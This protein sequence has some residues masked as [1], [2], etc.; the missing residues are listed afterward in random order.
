MAPA[1]SK[2]GWLVCCWLSSAFASHPRGTEAPAIDRLASMRVG[3]LQHLLSQ[4]NSKCPG[5]VE[6]ADYV[7]RCQ[8]VWQELRRAPATVHLVSSEYDWDI[9]E[10]SEYE[11]I[12]GPYDVTEPNTSWVIRDWRRPRYERRRC[13]ASVLALYGSCPVLE[14]GTARALA[15]DAWEEI[16]VQVLL[17]GPSWTGWVVSSSRDAHATPD[18][19][20]HRTASDALLP[21]TISTTWDT[22]TTSLRRIWLRSKLFKV[23]AGDAGRV[24]WEKTQRKA[25]QRTDERGRTGLLRAACNGKPLGRPSS[26]PEEDVFQ[27]N[28][29]LVGAELE[30]HSQVLVTGTPQSDGWRA[31]KYHGQ[32][33]RNCSMREDVKRFHC[34]RC[35]Y[36]CKE[37]G[38]SI[39]FQVTETDSFWYLVL[40]GSHGVAF[41][42]NL[43]EAHA[44]KS[45]SSTPVDIANWKYI[46][47]ESALMP[48]TSSA[49]NLQ[50]TTVQEL[51]VT[52][53]ATLSTAIGHQTVVLEG[54]MPY[55][56]HAQLRGAYT[57]LTWMPLSNG[58]YVYAHGVASVLGAL[59][60]LPPA[61]ASGYW[62]WSTAA[63]DGSS[64]SCWYVGPRALIGSRK[65]LCLSTC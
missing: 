22:S 17:G 61:D 63:T 57:R 54:S 30:G 43:R 20:Y 36:T 38:A 26:C 35:V 45:T 21:H 25:R 52:N 28:G 58:R 31:S 18:A 12:S 9:K 14:H 33:D 1:R 59:W 16:A 39:Y 47:R 55:D 37:S 49:S 48:F 53:I 40:K 11:W 8:H 64:K 60:A 50:V 27:E 41:Q 19:W 42:G 4:T 7:R 44:V 34:G 56:L 32:Y 2:L 6:K 13:P 23:L 51:E 15:G 62:M 65:G 46:K 29:L 5:C 10:G 3:E 24:A